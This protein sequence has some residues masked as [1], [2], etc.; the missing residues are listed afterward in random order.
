MKNLEMIFNRLGGLNPKAKIFTFADMVVD[1]FKNYGF[2]TIPFHS[3]SSIAIIRGKKN[4]LYCKI[5]V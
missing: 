4:L 2:N 5:K 1:D 3:R